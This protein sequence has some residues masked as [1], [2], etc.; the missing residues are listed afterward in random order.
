MAHRTSKPIGSHCRVLGVASK[1]INYGRGFHNCTW[2]KMAEKVVMV[3]YNELNKV[4]K[5]PTDIQKSEIELLRE[6]C[7]K[8]FKFGTNVKLEIIFQKYDSDWDA[9]I[10]LDDSFVLSNKDKLK[11]VVQPILTDIEVRSNSHCMYMY[12][13]YWSRVFLYQMYLSPLH[14]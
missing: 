1:S 14:Q 12:F 5:I 7:S 9:M 3:S 11:M 8:L 13:N 4:V 2:F 10:D 6:Q